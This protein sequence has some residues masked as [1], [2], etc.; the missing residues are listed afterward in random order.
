[1]DSCSV[2]SHLQPQ[3][4]FHETDGFT[5][6]R[7]Q[8]VMNRGGFAFVQKGAW[9]LTLTKVALI[10]NVSYFNFGGAWSFIWGDKPT[11]APRDDG[12]G[13]TWQRV[14]RSLPPV[15][16]WEFLVTLYID[17]LIV[18]SNMTQHVCD[19]V[20]LTQSREITFHV[21]YVN[22]IM[23]AKIWGAIARF[24]RSW[25]RPWSEQRPMLKPTALQCL[26]L[27]SRFMTTQ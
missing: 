18:L 13:L 25:M 1:M 2:R 16:C 23:F 26:S 7:R 20:V 8:K 6:N 19:K 12:T 17:W 14:P 4:H 3:R 11:K 5:Q 27:S 15:L 24:A 10:Y 22:G 21:K 9:H